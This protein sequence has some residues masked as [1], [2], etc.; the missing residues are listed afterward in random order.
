MKIT[1]TCTQKTKTCQQLK[2]VPKDSEK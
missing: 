2:S 1:H